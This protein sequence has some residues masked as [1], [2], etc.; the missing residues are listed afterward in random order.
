MEIFF[1]K[2]KTGL[3]LHASLPLIRLLAVAA[4]NITKIDVGERNA[5]LVFI[6]FDVDV[7]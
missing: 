5:I 6:W 1:R 4:A 7:G 3:G 2:R